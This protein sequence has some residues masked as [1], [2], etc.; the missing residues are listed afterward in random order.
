[1][2]MENEKNKAGIFLPATVNPKNIMPWFP[3]RTSWGGKASCDNCR[4]CE[5]K[6]PG[7]ICGA[8]VEDDEV[9][10]SMEGGNQ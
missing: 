9:Q 10:M 3:D 2:N 4:G 1:M 5:R 7:W 8:W 6:R